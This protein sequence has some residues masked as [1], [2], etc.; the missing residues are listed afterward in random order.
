MVPRTYMQHEL[1]NAVEAARGEAYKL[2]F[3]QSR[4]E[5][6]AKGSKTQRER[7]STILFGAEAGGREAIAAQLAYETD[8]SAEQ[9]IEV[10]KKLPRTQQQTLSRDRSRFAPGGLSVVD[11]GADDLDGQ[12]AHEKGKQIAGSFPAGLRK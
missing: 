11:G 10:L 8:M 3:D 12:S 7:L 9:A 2:A 1:D 4:A 5:G 6:F